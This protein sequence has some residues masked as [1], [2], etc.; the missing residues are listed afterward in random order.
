[1]SAL[2]LIIPTGATGVIGTAILSGP[3]PLQW[4]ALSV[5]ALAVVLIAFVVVVRVLGDEKRSSNAADLLELVVVR[6]AR[7]DRH[8]S[9]KKKR[10]RR[11]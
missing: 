6:R 3:G 1:M 11:R 10:R 8:R 5:V 9:K 2:R 4:L 7:A